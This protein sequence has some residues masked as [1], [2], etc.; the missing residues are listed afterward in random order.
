[1]LGSYRSDRVEREGSSTI[2]PAFR[3]LALTIAA[4]LCALPLR[5]QVIV[6]TVVESISGT[7]V[8]G[9]SIALLNL[10]GQTLVETHTDAEGKFAL[11]APGAGRYRVRTT[12]FAYVHAISEPFD[13]EAAATIMVEFR[14][15]RDAIRLDPLTVSVARRL[16]RLQMEGF[17]QR[18]R[19]GFGKF[20]TRDQIEASPTYSVT[21]LLRK[22]PGVQVIRDPDTGEFDVTFRG[23]ATLD[24]CLPSVMIDG[25]VVRHSGSGGFGLDS[26]SLDEIEAIEVYTG[27]AGL[28]PQLAG[29]NSF[30]G[31]I[32]FWMRR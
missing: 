17:Y 21:H 31:A 19:M 16:Q 22:Y 28:P 4:T 29:M 2:A 26:I 30:C 13:V 3:V 20:I 23:A 24:T 18:Q 6:G 9:A 5:A 25:I 7:T 11:R 15:A 27:L 32:V 10:E 1:M 12:H 14:L 8:K